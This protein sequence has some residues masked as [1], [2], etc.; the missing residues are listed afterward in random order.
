MDLFFSLFFFVV[1]NLR[2]HVGSP[3]QRKRDISRDNQHNAVM[4][5]L[6]YE[7]VARAFFV[8]ERE[9]RFVTLA[10]MTEEIPS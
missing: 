5:R 9:T 3:V 1:V 8:V 2:V 4:T 7:N 10:T 6:R